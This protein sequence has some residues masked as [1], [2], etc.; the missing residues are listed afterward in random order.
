MK[1]ALKPDEHVCETMEAWLG[2]AC[3]VLLRL[4]FACV[5]GLVFRFSCH[6]ICRLPFAACGT[7]RLVC[8]I[9][10][11]NAEVRKP[12]Y[13]ANSFRVSRHGG[14]VASGL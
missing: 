13:E 11:A 4:A 2:L 5:F 14:S 12:G 1:I 6:S 7:R 10:M 8:T 9:Q 3:T